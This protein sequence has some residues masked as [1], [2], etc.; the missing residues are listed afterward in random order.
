MPPSEPNQDPVQGEFFT[1]ASDLP[2][3]L[4]RE[5]IQ[6]SL[7]ACREGQSVRARFVFS[8]ESKA[9]PVADA[10]RYLQGL[11]QHI[12]AVAIA[13]GRSS[14]ARE[15][16]SHGDSPNGNDEVEAIG[17]ALAYLNRPM[18]YLAIEDF[19]TTGLT[20]DTSRNDEWEAGNN[21]WGFF[22]SVGI[23]SKGE[24]SGGSWGL[25]KWVFPDASSINAYLGVT[26][27]TDE[28]RFLLMGMAMLKTH[29]VDEVKYPPYGY[30]AIAADEKP[31]DQ[32]LPLPVDSDDDPDH[33]IQALLDLDLERLEGP[34]LSVVVPYPND[35]L[36]P[37]SVARAALKQYFLPI[38]REDL[39]VDIVHPDLGD[40]TINTGSITDE[41]NRI[42]ESNGDDESRE[43]L[44][45]IIDLAKWAIRL[46][47]S[48][49][50]EIAAPTAQN[51]ALESLE[52]DGL[53]ERFNR[54]ERL[55]FRL[56]TRVQRR[57][58]NIKTP[59][60]FHVYLERDDDV[61]EGHDYFVRGHLRIPKMDHIK[62]QKARALVVV[63]GE[64]PLGHLL[65]D[66]EGPAHTTWSPHAQ[67][68]K[69]RWIGGQSRVQEVRRATAL[70]LQRLVERPNEQQ[71]DALA[72]LFPGEPEVRASPI[73]SR[74]PGNGGSTRPHV[75][76]LNNSLLE[77]SRAGAG[78][79][80][81]AKKGAGCAVDSTWD[82]RFAYDVV[83]GN[84]FSQFEAGVTHG[85]L[86]FSLYGSQIQTETEGCEISEIVSENEL[87][88]VVRN[89]DFRLVVTGFDSRDVIVDLR[90]V[91]ELTTDSTEGAA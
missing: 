56:T 4:V 64:S 47:D 49:H 12:E 60:Y 88:F 25:G 71:F 74:Q 32:W 22:R 29:R 78:F 44:C 10:Q 33:F 18:T 83:R 21:F 66:A 81:R 35:E 53:R 46:D 36:T 63:D 40:R 37:C 72:D 54:G 67:R 1:A 38:V 79:S 34:G 16:S 57:K 43:S 51:N 41:V 13:S 75:G 80:V 6:N 20:G 24:D 69:E 85:C 8:G 19:G 77:V 14:V 30:F 9:L 45:G 27:R 59:S 58:T 73:Q 7:D 26:Q 31:D 84:P 90:P 89:E 28:S 87:R 91:E 76:S 17:D 3:R 68:L 50:I 15:P 48:D 2:E 70:L 86:D 23:S 5:A 82:L 52:I 61:S 65:R 11:K 42:S 55:A 39:V 62:R